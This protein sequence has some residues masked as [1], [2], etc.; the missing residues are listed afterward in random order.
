MYEYLS[1]AKYVELCRLEED[2]FRQRSL[3]AVPAAQS[4]VL[5]QVQ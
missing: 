3:S 4:P 2:Q 5:G 1:V